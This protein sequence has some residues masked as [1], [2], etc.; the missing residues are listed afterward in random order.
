MEDSSRLVVST[1]PH[2]RGRASIARDM[3][4]VAAAL[5]L[6]TIGAVYFFGLYVLLM[7][8]TALASSLLTE[9]V[10]KAMRRHPF[11][12]DGSTVVTAMLFVL[13]LPPRTPLWV[14]F[15]GSIFCVAIAKEAFGGLG[16]NIFNP[17]LAG[18]AFVTVSF[19]GALNRFISPTTKWLADGVTAATPLGEGSA[20]TLSKGELYWDLFFGNVAGST[21]E[22]SA[23]LIIA[24][25]LILLAFGLIKWQVPVFYIGTVFVLSLLL[26]EDALFQILAG[27]LM[28]GA[29]FMATDY[30]TTPLTT[31]G[32]IIFAIGAG[33][34]VALIRKLGSMPEGVAYSILLMNA[35]TPLIDR[36][37]RTKPFGFRRRAREEKSA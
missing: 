20:T 1:S 12:M 31:K 23:L 18:R 26:G 35:A 2:L 25:G 17:A 33:I 34:L 28:I 4:I 14:V 36:Y 3:Y 22:T 15:V 19:A 7:L 32:K 24:A 21:G 11:R 16:H 27:G 6:P 29:F 10:A 9:Y 37:V 13:I 30:V 8:A 5:L